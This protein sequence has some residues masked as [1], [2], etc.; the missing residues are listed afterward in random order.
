MNDRVNILIIEDEAILAMALSD[1]LEDDGYNVVGAA[2][3]GRKALDLFQNNPVD[4]ILCDITI[5]GEW[6]G[7]DTIRQLFTIRQAPV[8]YLTAIADRATIQRAKETLPAAYITKPFDTNQLRLAI[9]M[10]INN[11]SVRVLTPRPHGGTATDSTP[12]PTPSEKSSRDGSRTAPV[13]KVDD[14]LFVK[15]NYQFVKVLLADILY[16]EADNIHTTIVTPHRKYAVRLSMS[17]LLERLQY[18][19][20]VRIHRSFVVNLDRIDSFSEHE[21]TIGT[22]SIPL[23][24]NFKE[25]FM[26]HFPVC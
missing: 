11:F 17:H 13:L 14:A 4:L 9:E 10:A 18:E 3:N 5:K 23:G 1:Q 26:Q 24:R 21:V 6:D 8:I 15:Q 16:L 25:E 20:M 22:H 19:R 2:S 12:A 7:I